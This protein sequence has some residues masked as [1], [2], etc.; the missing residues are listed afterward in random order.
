ML[1]GSDR[2]GFAEHGLLQ[3]VQ[4]LQAV[5]VLQAALMRQFW[6]SRQSCDGLTLTLTLPP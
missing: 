4:V 3:A 5:R 6:C 1:T 2:E